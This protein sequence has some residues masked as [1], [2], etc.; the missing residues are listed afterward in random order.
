IAAE[1]HAHFASG[2]TAAEGVRL[3]E[4]RERGARTAKLRNEAN[5]RGS[6]LPINWQPSPAEVTFAVERGLAQARIAIQAEKFRNYWTAKSGAGATK[7]DWSATWRNWIFTA[8]ER[9]YGPPINRGH[10]PG[11]NTTPRR[12]STGSD[13]ILAGMARLASRID[14]RRVSNRA[15]GW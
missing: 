11:T 6:R 3:V 14:E 4:L 5:G 15:G 13:A 1:L 7:R 12:A 9:G 10:R 8:M 2:G